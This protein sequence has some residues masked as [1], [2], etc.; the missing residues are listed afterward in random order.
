[1]PIIEYKCNSCGQATER[2]QRSR[3]APPH[4]C[5]KCGSK[6]VQRVLSG[7]S[8]GRSGEAAASCDT[9]AGGPCFG[10]PCPTDSCRRG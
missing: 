4:V 9:C 6:D 7:F 8:V 1:M 10:N 2:L 5:Q 3:K